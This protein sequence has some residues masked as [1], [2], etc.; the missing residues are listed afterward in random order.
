MA[1][2]QKENG[3]APIANEL[4][5]AFSRMPLSTNEW[6][7]L[8]VVLRKTYGWKDRKTNQQKKE[9]VITTSQISQISGIGRSHAHEALSSLV[10]RRIVFRKKINARR[11]IYGL[12]KD[13]HLWSPDRPKPRKLSPGDG[14]TLSPGGGTTSEKLSPGGGHTIDTL[15]DTIDSSGVSDESRENENSNKPPAGGKIKKAGQLMQEALDK[16]KEGNRDG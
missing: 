11:F 1:S 2:P 10:D 4:L 12:Q 6:R 8:M 16:Y 3:F 9:D 5:V 15:I 14:T 7:V 13:Y